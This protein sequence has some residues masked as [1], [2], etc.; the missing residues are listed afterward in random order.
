M[1]GKQAVAN[2]LLELVEN[3]PE[4]DEP[5]T[6]EDRKALAQ[7]RLEIARGEAIPDEKLA[8]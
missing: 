6:E 1:R 7:A 2:R 8:S 5:L 3:A 4:D